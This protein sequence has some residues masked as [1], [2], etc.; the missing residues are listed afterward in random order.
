MRKEW[1]KYKQ[2]QWLRDTRTI[3][4]MMVSQERALTELKAV[5]EYLYEKAIEVSVVLT[6]NISII[7]RR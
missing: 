7:E 4:S 6:L 5:S 3:E 2:D 1:A